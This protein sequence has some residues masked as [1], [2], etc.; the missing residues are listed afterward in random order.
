MMGRAKN[1]GRKDFHSA[2]PRRRGI[3]GDGRWSEYIGMRSTRS[4]PVLLVISQNIFP[5]DIMTCL[6]AAG[7]SPAPPTLWVFW[8]LIWRMESNKL[9]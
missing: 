2:K 7:L 8:R 9:E 6:R 1:G 4:T 5:T 3:R